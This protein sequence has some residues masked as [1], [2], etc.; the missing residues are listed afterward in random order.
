MNWKASIV[1][2]INSVCLLFPYNIIGC[3]GSEPDPYDYFVSLFHREM[4]GNRSYSPFYYTNYQFLYDAQ[5]PVNTASATSAEWV[6]YCGKNVKTEEA[7]DFVCRYGRKDLLNLYNHLE[8][9]QALKLPDSVSRN[10][11]TAYFRQ[12]KD[13]EALGYLLY[14]KQVEPFVT[15]DW[16]SWEPIDRDSVNMA[17]LIKNGQQLGKAAKKE[18][19]KLRYGYQVLR[20]SHYSGN[21]QQCI[22]GYDQWIAPNKTNSVLQA[23][24]RGLKAGAYW[25]LGQKEN[26]AY[27]FSRLFSESDVK[28]VANY[29]SFDWCVKR[30]DE[31]SRVRCLAKCRTNEEKANMLGL[32]ALGSNTSEQEALEK[33]EALDPKSSLLPVLVTREINKLEEFLFTPSLQFEAGKKQVLIGYNE[34]SPDSEEYLNWKKKA[35]ELIRFC[36]I[37][38]ASSPYKP[39]F[40]LAASHAAVITK[41]AKAKDLLNETSQSTLSPLQKDQL[42]LT[43]LLYT[44]NTEKNLDAKAEAALLPSLQWLEKKAKADSS[45]APFYRR[46]MADILPLKYAQGNP[47]NRFKYI[48][49]KGVADHINQEWVKGGWGYYENALNLLR[50]QLN[51]QETEQLIRLMESRSASAYDQFLL[52]RTSFNKD[53]VNDLAGTAW[54]RQYKFREA[55]KWFSKVPASYY[56][57]ES[58]ATYLAANPFADLL[59]DTHAPTSQDTVRYTKLSFTRRMIALEEAFNKESDKERQ[60]KLAYEMAKGYYHMSYWGNSWMLVQYEWSSGEAGQYAWVDTLAVAPKGFNP[61]YYSV[62]KAREQYGRARS[63]SADKD[64]QARCV[65]MEA[66]CAQKEM[67]NIPYFYAY[68]TNTYPTEMG[69]WLKEFDKRYGYF[70]TLKNSY[71]TIPFYKEAFNTCSYLRD[72]LAT[73]K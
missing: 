5:E 43:R 57:T 62:Q 72:F 38:A 29:M 17:R 9:K 73:K 55:E 39:L 24:S 10:A 15:G 13:L 71:S 64:F 42:A 54:L 67:S 53:D 14:A 33:I 22:A 65:F 49:C 32:F 61:D 66:K 1:V 18:F 6:G 7:Y 34:T 69:R 70:S 59:Q 48:L 41:D 26:A 45:F 2:L 3:A 68:T 16:S 50:E 28:K 37:K 60:A 20:L 46:I 44:I 27:E 8:K 23:L 11:M 51:G 40:L 30:L 19:I 4:A 35:G 52:T 31:T 63:L 12:S 21:Y 36:N 56:Q 47:D 58:F 25:H